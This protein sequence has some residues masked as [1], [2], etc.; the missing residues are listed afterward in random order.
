MENNWYSWLWWRQQQE[1]NS[2]DFNSTHFNFFIYV[3]NQQLQGQLQ[4]QHSAD[5]GNVLQ[6]SAGGKS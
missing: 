1:H 3:R 4:S 5:T 2:I 6:E